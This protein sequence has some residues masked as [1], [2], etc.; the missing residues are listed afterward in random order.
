MIKTRGSVARCTHLLVRV[1]PHP[2]ALHHVR[3]R[4]GLLLHRHPPPAPRAAH[5]SGTARPLLGSA[6]TASCGPSSIVRRGATA[7]ASAGLPVP[8]HPLLPGRPPVTGPLPSA[9]HGERRRLS[10][11]RTL[12]RNN[13]PTALWL[14]V[15]VALPQAPYN[16]PAT[17]P[18][19]PSLSV[20]YPDCTVGTPRRDSLP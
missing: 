11:S 5:P 1:V 12:A 20:P 18:S 13:S 8:S 4:A 14:W 16:T 19:P 15:A 10:L 9:S 6:S 2:A 17:K 7:P 3:G